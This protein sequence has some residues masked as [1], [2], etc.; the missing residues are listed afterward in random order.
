[1]ARLRKPIK[2]Y[3]YHRRSLGLTT[4]EILNI[5]SIKR[6]ILILIFFR[7]RFPKFKDLLL[8][9]II[10]LYKTLKTLRTEPENVEFPKIERTFIKIASINNLD[11]SSRFRFRNSADL[12]RVF[13]CFN[14]GPYI[15][16]PNNSKVPSEM[17]FL[18]SLRRLS[19]PNRIADL[20][21]E[22]GYEITF[23]SRAF[24]TFISIIVAKFKHLL[25]NS[26]SSWKN[27]FPIFSNVIKTQL[28]KNGCNHLNRSDIV[29]KI[30]GYIDNTNF[31]TCVPGGG[32]TADG[33]NA[34]RNDP[35]IQEAAYSGY[36]HI[37]GIKIQTITF[38]NGLI[39]YYFN[40]NLY[41]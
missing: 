41:L 10:S 9:R 16:L 1:M 31:S 23:W 15:Y 28:I 4:K 26:I 14:L 39:G 22:F 29:N 21:A 20:L 13:N 35:L 8:K 12:E 25:I 32:P 27:E 33:P 7:T 3:A 37:H 30:I 17:V 6:K 40:I 18:Y 11:C 5:R 34:P 2:Q 36:K 24:H 38:P 19:Y